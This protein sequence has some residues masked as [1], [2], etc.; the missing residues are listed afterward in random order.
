MK[1]IYLHSF[2]YKFP[3]SLY[4][5]NKASREAPNANEHEDERGQG[6]T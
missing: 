3:A 4:S 6:A 2:V 1:Q 5:Y